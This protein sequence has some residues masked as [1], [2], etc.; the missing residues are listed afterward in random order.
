MKV[1]QQHAFYSPDTDV[2]GLSVTRYHHLGK[3]TS[4]VTGTGQN[5]CEIKLETIFHALGP[6]KAGNTGCF[7]GKG[8]ASRW[9]TFIEAD[10]E[11]VISGFSALGVSVIPSIETLPLIEK[12]VLLWPPYYSGHLIRHVIS[13]RIPNSATN[14]C[15]FA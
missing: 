14:E 8:I 3:N 15:V 12:F 11:E 10:E 5:H 7:S 2:S 9:K 1:F 6:A 4:F 13:K